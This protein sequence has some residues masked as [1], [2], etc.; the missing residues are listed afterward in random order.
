MIN[1]PRKSNSNTNIVNTNQNNQ[2]NQT[3]N[4]NNQN[5]TGNSRRS[6]QNN[7]NNT[8]NST[9]NTRSNQSNQRRNASNRKRNTRSNQTDRNRD[10]TVTTQPPQRP[11]GGQRL[12]PVRRR[13]R[14]VNTNFRYN[15]LLNV[16]HKAGV[17]RINKQTVLTGDTYLKE[18]VVK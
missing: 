3:S 16:A 12:G 4:Q 14:R 9:T 8:G 6:N 5:N 18:I 13:A 11:V 2:N 1:H 7:Q 17:L 10:V 15:T